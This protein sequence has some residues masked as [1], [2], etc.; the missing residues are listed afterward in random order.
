MSSLNK[1]FKAAGVWEKQVYL[2]ELA[3]LGFKLKAVCKPFKAQ[4]TSHTRCCK[5]YWGHSR[6][7]QRLSRGS[8]WKRMSNTDIM[9]NNNT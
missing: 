2:H 7:M 4:K 3:C 1:K 5:C 6:W 8:S 9:G